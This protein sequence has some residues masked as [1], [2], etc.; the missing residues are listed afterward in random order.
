MR[1]RRP[2]FSSIIIHSWLPCTGFNGQGGIPINPIDPEAECKKILEKRLRIG[3][4]FQA[5]TVAVTCIHL[6][7][8]GSSYCGNGLDCCYF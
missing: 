2:H 7:E 5:H 3:G 6:D 8:V 4:C 1:S